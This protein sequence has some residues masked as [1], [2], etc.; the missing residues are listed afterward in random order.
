MAAIGYKLSSMLY[1]LCLDFSLSDLSSVWRPLHNLIEDCPLAVCDASTVLESDLVEA[2][3]VA[4]DF[5][6]ELYYVK[7]NRGQKWHWL[8]SQTPDEVLVTVQF[9]SEAQT[10]K[11]KSQVK[12]ECTKLQQ[13]C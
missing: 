11:G 5:V 7:H 8:S 6:F 13:P 3:R 4:S 12:V 2:D 9:D 1:E 10:L